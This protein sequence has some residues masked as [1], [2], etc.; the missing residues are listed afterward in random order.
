MFK[1]WSN[2][3]DMWWCPNSCGY[4][5]NENEAGV[6]GE[7]EAFNIVKNANKLIDK[8]KSRY[9]GKIVKIGE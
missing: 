6:Y 5:S 9:G 2:E 8:I 7:K 3:H 4:T 1:I